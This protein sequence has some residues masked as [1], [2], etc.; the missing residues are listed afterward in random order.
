MK[1]IALCFNIITVLFIA[2][3][4]YGQSAPEKEYRLIVTEGSAEV[5]APNDS[6]VISAAV[7]T[8]GRVLE[9][10]GNE[11][12]IKMKAILNVLKGLNIQ[13]IKIETTGFQVTP[14]R[15]YKSKTP[16]ITGYEV[17][18]TL[19][20]KMEGFEPGVLSEYSTRVIGSIL[21]NGA[22]S[23][24]Y[25]NSYIKDIEALENE[26]F[27]LA[28]RKA[29]KRSEILA[30]A[31]GVKIKKIVNISTQPEERIMKQFAM[32]SAAM[33]EQVDMESPPVEI[34]ESQVAA[35]VTFSV[36]LE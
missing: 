21:E 33:P 5:S 14:K 13:N 2:G 26:A 3:F 20:I 7:V 15:D 34:G 9:K 4:A 22:N 8:E 28:T 16:V 1:K 11:N 17:Q 32:R 12:S 35:R 30:A 25:I 18:N 24:N 29:K 19:E 23:I 27:A 36:E 10:V 6:V 31:A